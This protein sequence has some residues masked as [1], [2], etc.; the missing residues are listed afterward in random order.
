[1]KDGVIK[2]NI[3]IQNIADLLYLL[4]VNN[5][6]ILFSFYERNITLAD[7]RTQKFILDRSMFVN[8]D[9][10]DYE[11]YLGF[12]NKESFLI[13]CLDQISKRFKLV[14]VE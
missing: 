4:N 5:S 3:C 13:N 8:V 6:L 12:T 11:C 2:Y 9:E 7:A 1:M 10:E 14:L